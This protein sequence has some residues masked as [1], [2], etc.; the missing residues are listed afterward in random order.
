MST[1]V[2]ALFQLLRVR[3]YYKNLVLFI[4][5]FFAGEIF[6]VDL[7]PQL[8]LAFVLICLASSF[9]YII[10]DIRD[11]EADKVH[12]EKAQSRPLANGDLSVGFAWVLLLI[13]AGILS[14]FIVYYIISQNLFA[15]FLGL[16]I[17]NGL[18]YNF[19]FKDI[20]FADIISLSTIYIWR[21]LAGC[22]MIDVRISPWLTITIF[23]FAM[24]LA[25]GKRIAD[26]ELLG[27]QNAKKHKKSYD[28]YSQHLLDYIIVMIATSLFIMYT[29]YCV[30][31]PL[32]D[33]SIVPKEN[34]GLL[35][36]SAPVAL[37][38]IIR[39]LYLVRAKPIIARN[40]EKMITDLP[41]L[42]G[43]GF[44]GIMVLIL[45]YLEIT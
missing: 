26:L 15:V 42:I 24:L 2:K 28:K 33:G 22:A 21:A 44:L 14:F 27:D 4:G 23:L 32:E 17:A 12:P 10:N 43:G 37:F 7:Y 38:L 16:I 13:I 35:I 6:S 36:Y 39:F 5:V 8:V 9:M 19:L 30:L 11:V 31:G 25:A 45:Y 20:A 29:L 1:K 34:Q 18:A 40:A 3:Q 41:M